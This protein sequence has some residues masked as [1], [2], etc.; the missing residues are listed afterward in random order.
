V[1]HEIKRSAPAAKGKIMWYSAHAIFYFKCEQQDSILVHE[2]VYLVRSGNEEDAL[3]QAI[4]I[5]RR[6]EDLNED[7]H[8]ELN[9]EPVQY[10]FA[11]IR[12]VVAV[13]LNPDTAKDEI[14]SGL[15]VTYSE[16]EVDTIEDVTRLAGGEFVDVLYRE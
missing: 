13:E 11:G 7:N 9:G 5:A 2:N 10:L 15:E 4:S 8:L 6:S 3:D 1:E 14:A 12:K 16:L